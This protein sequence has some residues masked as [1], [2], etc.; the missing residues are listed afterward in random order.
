MALAYNWRKGEYTVV[1][2]EALVLDGP[3]RL[4]K[5]TYIL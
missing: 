4:K 2:E 3:M 5:A 1:T